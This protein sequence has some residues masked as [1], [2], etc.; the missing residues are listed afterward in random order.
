MLGIPP[1]EWNEP[2]HRVDIAP[3]DQIS[4]RMATGKESGANKMWVPGESTSG[5]IPEA[6]I[7]PVPKTKIKGRCVAK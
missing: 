1:N 6:V 2:I 5:G 7:D 3:S 4:L